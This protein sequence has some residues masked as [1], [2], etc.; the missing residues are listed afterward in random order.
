MNGNNE[1]HSK[2]DRL[3]N[4]NKDGWRGRQRDSQKRTHI[5]RWTGRWEDR[6]QLPDI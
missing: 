1:R 5:D 2:A 3:T 4:Q 6:K